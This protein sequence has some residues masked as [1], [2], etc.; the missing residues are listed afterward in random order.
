MVGDTGSAAILG[1]VSRRATTETPGDG[2]CMDTEPSKLVLEARDGKISVINRA[3]CPLGPSVIVC[4]SVM[5][6]LLLNSVSVTVFDV[7][8]CGFAKA[9]PTFSTP[10]WRL[11]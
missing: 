2:L 10:A 9:I 7:D 1:P 4:V 3:R 11:A 8:C 5:S 6:P